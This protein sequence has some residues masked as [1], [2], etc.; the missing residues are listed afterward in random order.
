[1]RHHYNY[2]ASHLVQCTSTQTAYLTRGNAPYGLRWWS[3]M[4]PFGKI[5][6]RCRHPDGVDHAGDCFISMPKEAGEDAGKVL[7]IEKPRGAVSVQ[8]P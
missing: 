7:I 4:E 1:M 5:V 2:C 3:G 6:L 8:S